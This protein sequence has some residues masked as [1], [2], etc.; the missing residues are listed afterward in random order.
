[1]TGT[2]ENKEASCLALSLMF[3]FLKD[4]GISPAKVIEDLQ[5]DQEY[6]LNTSNWIDVD[7]Y[8]E[9]EERVKALFPREKDLFFKIGCYMSKGKSFGFIKLLGYLSGS[10]Y[11]IYKM[12]EKLAPRH[13][14]RFITIKVAERRKNVEAGRNEVV[15]KY[16]FNDDAGRY[17]F[18]IDTVRGIMTVIP[19]LVGFDRAKV[20]V[21]IEGKVVTYTIRYPM[22]GNILK[23]MW[24]YVFVR[25]SVLPE[26]YRDLES[27][28]NALQAKVAKI[29]FQGELSNLLGSKMEINTLIRTFLQ[30]MGS[31]FSVSRILVILPGRGGKTGEPAYYCKGFYDGTEKTYHTLDYVSDVEHVAAMA[32]EGRGRD[33][34]PGP[35]FLRLEG[36]GIETLK[37]SDAIYKHVFD[38]VEC[39]LL[40]PLDWSKKSLGFILFG[41]DEGSSVRAEEERFFKNVTDIF[42]IYLN[43]SFTYD[44][45][46]QL[47]LGLEK[48]VHEKT[49][50]LQSL[51]EALARELEEKAKFD[52]MRSDFLMQVGHNLKTPL[53]LILSPIEMLSYQ[54]E[55]TDREE[56]QKYLDILRTNAAR[57]KSMVFQLLNYARLESDRFAYD[58]YDVDLGA[59]LKECAGEFSVLGRK[60]NIEVL[61]EPFDRGCVV[62]GNRDLLRSAI[63]NIAENA[64]KYS[65]EGS[66]ITI[67]GRVGGGT[68]EVS[69]ADSGGGLSEKELKTI[70]QPY[71]RGE[72]ANHSVEGWGIGLPLADAIIRKHGGRIGAKSEGGGGSCFSIFLPVKVTASLPRVPEGEKAGFEGPLLD[73]KI[74]ALP[75]LDMHPVSEEKLYSLLDD[76]PPMKYTVLVAEDDEGFL[77]ILKQKLSK[78]FVVITALNG[79]QVMKRLEKARPDLIISDIL[80]TPLDGLKLCELLKED[81]RY[82][83]IPVILMTALEGTDTTIESFLRGAND[84][85]RKPFSMDELFV[86]IR[87]QLKIVEAGRKMIMSEKIASLGM[88]MAGIAHEIKNPMNAIIN[89][90]RPITLTLDAMGEK[91]GSGE[92][93]GDIDDIRLLLGVV[94]ESSERI[95]DVIQGIQRYVSTPETES[96]EIRPE[97]IIETALKIL[98]HKMRGRID[99]KR[100]YGFNGVVQGSPG[101]LSQL[102]LNLVDNA[103]SAIR[104][105]GVIHIATSSRGGDLIVTISDTGQGIPE[106]IREKIFDPFFTTKEIG[107]GTGLGLSI[108]KE[109]VESHHGR[110]EIESEPGK[111]TEFKV[112][113]PLPKDGD[114]E[115]AM[116]LGRLTEVS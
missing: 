26:T 62:R 98:G 107:L 84:Y 42:S 99:V 85:M 50:E 14:F 89:A 3:S 7:T 27:A 92:T 110:I 49:K 114:K 109:I 74:L 11:A 35:G 53:A 63:S 65:P 64:V 10:P 59:I 21:T 56:L 31:K 102:F 17:I 94:S 43:N 23:R 19:E 113:L 45:L 82:A 96:R 16:E 112:V 88:L 66:A 91:D 51:N 32:A 48:Q 95:M 108:S 55:D 4:K 86:R 54:T 71:V 101:R 97:E 18:F 58:F 33:S 15:L 90:V 30:F 52:R 47:N 37:A 100:T 1:M 8:V 68:C 78:K 76:I 34:S 77:E 103:I 75:G 22:K 20:E 46:E 105:R 111:G 13:L 39:V 70:F 115:S 41:V 69:I 5:Y 28:H 72:N 36:D 38:S 44:E 12:C 79:M 87:L 57:L 6:L 2:I 73:S 93:A 40:Y 67:S 106:G 83:S 24:K 60:K 80:M 104:D 81:A 116:F 29:E 25:G 61:F 9:I